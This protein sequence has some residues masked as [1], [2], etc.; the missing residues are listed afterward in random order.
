MQELR[1]IWPILRSEK[2]HQ[3]KTR[4]QNV[5][6]IVPAFWGDFVY[7]FFS[8]IRNGPKKTHEQIFATHPVQGQSRT[9][10]YVDVFF[11]H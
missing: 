9:F 2:T 10:V 7:V 6:G 1:L 11:F 3:E 8:P 4:K 5:H